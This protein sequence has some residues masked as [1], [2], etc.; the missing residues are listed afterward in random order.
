MGVLMNSEIIMTGIKHDGAKP[1]YDL[2]P[3]RALDEVAKVLTFGAKKY[4]PHNW[5]TLTDL[6]SRYLA[7]SL[8]HI[9][10]EMQGERTDDES[11]LSHLAHAITCLMFVIEHRKL[12]E[13]DTK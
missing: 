1:R 2:I 12:T 4:P 10:A 9:S 11:G 3:F 7:A 5:K 8:R 13:G 6:E